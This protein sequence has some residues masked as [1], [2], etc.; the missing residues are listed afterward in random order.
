LL[1]L[2]VHVAAEFEVVD[3][4]AARRTGAW[5]GTGYCERFPDSLGRLRRSPPGSRGADVRTRTTRQ[6]GLRVLVLFV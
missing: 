6:C 3:D 1:N 4:H 5:I 2:L